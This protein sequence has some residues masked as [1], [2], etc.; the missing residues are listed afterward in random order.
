MRRWLLL[1][2]PDD[3]GSG[4]KG[5]LKVSMVVLGT[6]DEPPVSRQFPLPEKQN[7]KFV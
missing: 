6:G 2:D 1:S 4:A 7:C 3:S 5:Y